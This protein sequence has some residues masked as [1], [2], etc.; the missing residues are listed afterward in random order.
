M[1][2][3][4]SRLT[5]KWGNKGK[6]W[7]WARRRNPGDF[8]VSGLDNKVTCL[9]GDSRHQ[10]KL[11]KGLTMLSSDLVAL[12][13]YEMS[14]MRNYVKGLFPHLED[15]NLLGS[16]RKILHTLHPQRCSWRE[17]IGLHLSYP[18]CKTDVSMYNNI[19]QDLHR[20]P[21]VKEALCSSPDHPVVV[22][23]VDWDAVEP[24]V[25][26]IDALACPLSNKDDDDGLQ[27]APTA[28]CGSDSPLSASCSSTAGQ[29]LARQVGS[30]KLWR[31]PE[32]A[33][34]CLVM[35]TL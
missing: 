16:H 8:P 6:C 11:C 25:L 24:S 23:L 17:F 14:K 2:S 34:L 32:V 7:E 4:H 35:I 12:A 27:K 33:T 30:R 18:L 19:V 5:P 13:I 22:A 21:G 3:W 20:V 15:N 1:D 26:V 29:L 9:D 28:N 10:G 31:P